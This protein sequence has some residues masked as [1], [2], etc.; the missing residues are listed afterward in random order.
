MVTRKTLPAISSPA[1]DSP[2]AFTILPAIDLKDGHCVRLKQGR[3]D[4]ITVYAGDPAAMAAQWQQQ[5]ATYLHVV[6]LDG[7]F[8]GRPVHLK[9]IAAIRGALTIPFEVGG[10]LRTDADIQSLLDLGVDRVILGTRA[11]EKTADLAR[12]AGRFGAALAVGI[13]ARNGMVQT[14]GW[15][16]TTTVNGVDL[17]TR[18]AEA[19]IATIIYTDTATDGMLTGPNYEA[20]R[21][22]CLAAEK[23]SI[24][25]SGGISTTSDIT[26][27]RAMGIPNLCGAIVGK[28]LYEAR[29]TL[30]GL[31]QAAAAP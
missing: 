11:C 18:V 1:P 29:V 12:L 28:A 8:Q 25:A 9:A 15:V 31:R 19:G 10:G 20:T 7:A 6:D 23:T 17:A 4:A 27:Y 14:K 30:A 2:D 13:D 5:G 26:R 21:A 22:V 16:T 24:I 3:A